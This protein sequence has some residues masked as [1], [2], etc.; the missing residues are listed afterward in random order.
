MFYTFMKR[1][2]VAI[3]RLGQLVLTTLL[4]VVGTLAANAQFSTVTITEVETHA[5]CNMAYWRVRFTV[6][7][8]D[9]NGGFIVQ[10]IV[11]SGDVYNCDGVRLGYDGAT[12][13]ESWPVGPNGTSSGQAWPASDGSG[14]MWNDQYKVGP[15]LANTY[16]SVSWTGQVAFVASP[17]PGV[18]PDTN[19]PNTWTTTGVPMSGGLSATTTEPS[20]WAALQASGKLKDHNAQLTWHCCGDTNDTVYF[21]DQTVVVVEEEVVDETDPDHNDDPDGGDGTGSGSDGDGTTDDSGSGKMDPSGI[22]TPPMLNVPAD[23]QIDQSSLD[24]E[25]YPVPFDDRITVALALDP[26]S[27]LEVRLVNMSGQVVFVKQERFSKT[28]ELNLKHLPHGMYNLQIQDLSTGAMQH[29][30]VIK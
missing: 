8:P 25:V 11:F 28:F 27:D 26:D 30:T 4:L 19:T 1:P 22:N 6:D 12:Y 3:K 2:V 23:K 17:A 15:S 20:Y 13:W 14:N 10:K 16:G 24:F 5:D 18:N 21:H 7:N 29:R 9:S